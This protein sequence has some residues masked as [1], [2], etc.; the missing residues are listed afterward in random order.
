MLRL[1]RAFLFIIPALFWCA[2]ATAAVYEYERPHKLA[3]LHE[4]LLAAGIPVER[5]EGN[6]QR[7]RITVPDVVAQT[8]L[9]ALVAA[10]DP[11]ALSSGEAADAARAAAQAQAAADAAAQ[12]Q[13]TAAAKLQVAVDRL[14]DPSQI[15]AI[16]DALFPDPTYTD[17]QRAFFR[18]L[19]RLILYLVQE[20]AL[21]Q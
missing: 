14:P 3:R 15:A 1:G 20:R 4:E 17:Q 19:A 21:D 11:A 9:D 16:V 13:R 12:A 10:H 8:T 2:S 18:R 6:G 5:V 7:L